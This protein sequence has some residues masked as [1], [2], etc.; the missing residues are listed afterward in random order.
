MK[1]NTL[2]AAIST[3]ILFYSFFTVH[4]QFRIEAQLRNRLEFRNGYQKL[5][6]TGST[7]LVL[8]SQR[9]RLLFLYESGNVKLN[10]TPQDVRIWGGDSTVSSSGIANNTTLGIY[11]AYAEVRLG[12][13]GWI[14]AGRQALKYDNERLFSIRNWNQN[15][16]TYDALLFKLKYHNWNLHFGGS[17]NT[18]KDAS[19]DNLYPAARIKSLNF[20]WI[21]RKFSDRLN[22]SLVHVAS[23]VTKT[24]TTNDIFFRQTSG[25]F[26][27][28]KA[29]K[30]NFSGNIYFQYG[31]NKKGIPVNAFLADADLSY[32]TGKLTPGTGLSFLS[33]NSKT[34]AAQTTD[35]LFDPLYGARH[36]FFGL[37]DYY[38][39]FSSST[40]QGGLADYYFYLD[41]SI[42]KRASIRNIFHHF[43][44]AKTNPTTP[45]DKNLGFENDF[46]LKYGLNEWASLE[47]SYM[48]YL[49][50]ESLRK[51]QEIPESKFYQ[52][53]YV[54]LT[55]SPVLY[56]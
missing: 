6:A 35:H 54:Q 8:V 38:S 48:F 14:S 46:V 13:I 26:T 56:K 51:M 12:K 32:K 42:S 25:L 2:K 1:K 27:E 47:S 34:G 31:K 43:R 37:M 5:V 52:F 20:V 3:M 24:D 28:Y 33:G 45:S 18:L 55:V 16:L 36:K 7:P 41:Y 44:L 39:S 50:T 15:G 11:E 21:N 4:A 19:S 22:L 30:L 53:F 9:T 23:G 40:K 29:G 17:W 49:P 10:I